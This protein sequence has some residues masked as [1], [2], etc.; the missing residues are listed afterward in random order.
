MK[1]KRLN[2]EMSYLEKLSKLRGKYSSPTPRFKAI[3]KFLDE[4]QE[5]NVKDS[6]KFDKDYDT[7]KTDKEIKEEAAGTTLKNILYL[8]DVIENL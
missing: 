2:E 6:I 5:V 8:A 3:S 7:G 1:F 4:L